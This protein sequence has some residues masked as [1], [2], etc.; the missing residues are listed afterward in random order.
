MKPVHVETI[1][2]Y[3]DLLRTEHA[4]GCLRNSPADAVTAQAVVIYEA[5]QVAHVGDEVAPVLLSHHMLVRRSDPFGKRKGGQTGD[6]TQMY[7]GRH[8][9]GDVFSAE[10]PPFAWSDVPVRESAVPYLPVQR[11][12]LQEV[13]ALLES[14]EEPGAHLVSFLLSVEEVHPF[15][16]YLTLTER[17]CVFCC[18]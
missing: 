18:S 11:E 17:L 16:L 4:T 13:P 10:H 6:A 9:P 12:E 2:Q 7:L 1:V 8:H 14:G 3:P 15:C 5:L